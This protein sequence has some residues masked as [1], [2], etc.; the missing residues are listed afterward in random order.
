M[1]TG[2]ATEPSDTTLIVTAYTASA[3]VIPA[4]A[5]SPGWQVIGAFFLP[6]ACDVR[7][8]AIMSVSDA[9]LVMRVRLFD[10][11]TNAEI[12]GSYAVTSSTVPGTR[13]LSGALS[14]AGN[15]SYQIQAECVGGVDAGLFGAFDEASLTGTG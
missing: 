2:L 12:S 9:S 4:V 10:L 3:Q 6:L 7:L 11:V 1:P 14:L 13:A 15:Q 8:E 5:A